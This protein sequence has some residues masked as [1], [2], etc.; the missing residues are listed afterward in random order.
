MSRIRGSSG[1][2][3]RLN[4]R[5][6]RTAYQM[7]RRGMC[8]ATLCPSNPN[9][10]KPMF[11]STKLRRASHQERTMSIQ[12]QGPWSL[13]TIKC[14]S[15]C[16]RYPPRSCPR[17][18]KT[19]LWIFRSGFP[20]GSRTRSASG[21]TSST[22]VVPFMILYCSFLSKLDPREGRNRFPWVFHIRFVPD[23]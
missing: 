6:I 21:C 14:C 18:V 1:L 16:S 4:I 23:R 5:M 7:Q 10:W 17:T 11:C 22:H 19:P 13:R 20:S 8:Q 3:C 12:S 9:T 15:F 2:F